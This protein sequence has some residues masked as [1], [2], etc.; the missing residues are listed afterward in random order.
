M[1]VTEGQVLCTSCHSFSADLGVVVNFL[2]VNIIVTRNFSSL[3]LIL[4]EITK[5]MLLFCESTAAW[6]LITI[7]DFLYRVI[8][9]KAVSN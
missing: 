2:L 5:Y 1:Y 3:K 8:C 9:P 6:T 7:N 4:P